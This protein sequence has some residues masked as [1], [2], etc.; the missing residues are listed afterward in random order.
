MQAPTSSRRNWYARVA[1]H[2]DMT[3]RKTLETSNIAANKCALTTSQNALA[4]I[5]Q[6]VVNTPTE[7]RNA[8]S[9][10]RSVHVPGALVKDEN[11]GIYGRGEPSVECMNQEPLA[12][13]EE[14][15]SRYDENVVS[16][17]NRDLNL[18]GHSNN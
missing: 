15:P 18:V 5:T 10:S 11:E 13:Y 1:E 2:K 3:S 4:D 6:R 8:P 9:C 7:Q 14:Y 17:A 16:T 12:P